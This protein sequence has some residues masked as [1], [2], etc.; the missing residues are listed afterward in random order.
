MSSGASEI[1][2]IYLRTGNIEVA[3]GMNSLGIVGNNGH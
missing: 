2:L 3:V 1:S